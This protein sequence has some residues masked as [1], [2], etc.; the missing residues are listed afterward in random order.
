MTQTIHTRTVLV[1]PTIAKAWLAKAKESGFENRY[2]QQTVVNSYADTMRQGKWMLN[3]EALVFDQNGILINGQHRLNAVI[4]A[5]RDIEFLVVDGV[6]HKAFST[7]D[8]GR[9]R[10]LGQL[11]SMN[12]VENYNICASIVAA[13]TIMKSGAQLGARPTGLKTNARGDRHQRKSNNAY[14]DIF[15]AD[16]DHFI[17]VTLSTMQ[18]VGKRRLLKHSF[19]GASIYH[20][21][22]QLK[23][24]YDFVVDFFRQVC[25]EPANN[26]KTN[27]IRLL[28]ERLVDEKCAKAHVPQITIDNLVYK[29]FN[30]YVEGKSCQRLVWSKELD[31][32]LTYLPKCKGKINA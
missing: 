32:F 24:D 19:I 27:P 10:T 3:G 9:N 23:W 25:I 2:I 30:K 18:V 5:D 16:R 21:T 29:A 14:I 1:T 4:K 17:K 11:L 15:N 20:L 26:N 31:G 13:A 6:D 28:H 8:C 12:G 22:R 7:F